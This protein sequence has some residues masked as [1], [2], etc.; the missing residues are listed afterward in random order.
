VVAIGGLDV[1]RAAEA[2]RQ[3]AD[4]IAVLSGIVTAADPEA[5][6]RADQE[7]IAAVPRD[8]APPPL[9]RPTLPYIPE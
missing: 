7:A 2:A 9:P 4:G 8:A 5:A 6:I 1:P 3:G